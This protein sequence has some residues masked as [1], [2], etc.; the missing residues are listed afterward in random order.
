[1]R[2]ILVLL[3]LASSISSCFLDKANDKEPS[4]NFQIINKELD[5]KISIIEPK[6]ERIIVINKNNRVDDVIDLNLKDS[7]ISAIKLA[8][9]YQ[10]KALKIRNWGE[11]SITNTK[12]AVTLSTR[13]YKDKLLYK[14]T[15]SPGDSSTPLKARQTTIILR[16]ENG[17]IVEKINPFSSWVTIIDE[18]GI[19]AAEQ[20][21][22][23]VPMT[24]DNYLEIGSF[25]PTWSFK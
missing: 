7:D 20:A 16:D 24:L 14:L 4:S 1:V 12:Y 25:S 21:S 11:Q 17:F 9:E 15:F 5:G 8:K 19:P 10:D 13:Y 18:E 23:E 3:I 6:R 2:N 22:G